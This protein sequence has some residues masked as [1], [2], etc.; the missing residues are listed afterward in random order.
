MN[1]F[2]LVKDLT[3]ERIAGTEAEGK[4]INIISDYLQKLGVEPVIENWF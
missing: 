4:A 3:F 2:A 1:T